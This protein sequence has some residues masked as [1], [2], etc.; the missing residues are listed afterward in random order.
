MNNM[1]IIIADQDQ[2][3]LT[4]LEL[5][6]V[7]MVSEE[8]VINIISSKDYFDD[9]FSVPQKAEI[10][11]IN[12]NLF[13]ENI[14]KHDIENVYI[15]TE[16]NTK[17]IFNGYKCIYKYT[18]IKEIFELIGEKSKIF[19]VDSINEQLENKLIV[20]YSP[21]GGSGKTF[22]SVAMSTVLKEYNKK[23]LYINTES[24]Q[25]FSNILF[26]E[27][28]FVTKGF[29]KSLKE[30]DFNILNKLNENISNTY[31]EYLKPLGQA[32]SFSNISLDN[33]IYLIDKI[34]EKKL[35]DYIIVDTSVEL[36]KDKC[37]LVNKA[38]KIVVVGKQDKYSSVK[39]DYFLKNIDTSVNNK[40]IFIC[41]MFEENKENFLSNEFMKNKCSIEEKIHLISN[42]DMLLENIKNN[43]EIKQIIQKL[44]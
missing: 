12:E 24:L 26:D 21:I 4:P 41:N 11:L 9:F 35:Y 16:D 20:V 3:Y 32:M 7:E 42:E 23:I 31:F 28:T 30:K 38:D 18:N 14:N 25:N 27:T 2:D 10:L 33:Y 19:D 15:L 8:S 43:N 17:E 22:L 40:F 13:N 5:Q 34:K 39:M 6:L 37:N 29:E 36:D 1:D 44:I